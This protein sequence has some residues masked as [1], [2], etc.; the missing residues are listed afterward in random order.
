LGEEHWELEKLRSE[1]WLSGRKDGIL[2]K[3]RERLMDGWE[4]KEFMTYRVYCI[5]V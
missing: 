5:G 2:R 4:R 3:K 1:V